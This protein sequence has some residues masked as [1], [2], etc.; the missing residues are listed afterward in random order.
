MMLSLNWQVPENVSLSTINRIVGNSQGESI[1]KPKFVKENMNKKVT[2]I[3]RGFGD[4]NQ[5][6]SV[7]GKEGGG[8]LGWVRVDGYGYFLK[9]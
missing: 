2:G 6:P 3:S 5:N 8:G 9:H 4:S 1:K 7:E